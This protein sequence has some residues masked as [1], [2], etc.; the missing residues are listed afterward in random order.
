M[1]IL[2][3]PAGALALL[4]SAVPGLAFAQQS[5]PPPYPA[6]EDE[7]PW[8]QPQV[9]VTPVDVVPPAY[10]SVYLY[11][12]R[13]LLARFDG[14]GALWLPTGGVYRVVAMRGER[15]VWNGSTTTAG[16][17]VSLRWPVPRAFYPAPYPSSPRVL[18]A[19]VEQGRVRTPL[20]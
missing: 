18:T 4:I 10:G 20:P 16:V 7:T 2:I 9:S 5:Y 12:G 3:I 8:G 14:P 13:R 6:D 17:P 1:N 15:I 19:P 11:D